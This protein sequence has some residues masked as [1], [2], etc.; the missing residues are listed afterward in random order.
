MIGVRDVVLICHTRNN[1]EA[2]LQ[3]LRKLIGR[4]F[5]RRSIN[6]V[7]DILLFSPLR[8][9]IIQLFH[10]FQGKCSAFLRCMG[11]TEHP[12]THL[13][14]TGITEGYRTVV[15]VEE[16]INGLPLL[17]TCKRT[18]L[19]ENR[20][21]IG[22]RPA[23]TLMTKAKCF[24]AKLEPLIQNL[25]ERLFLSFR[26]AGNIHKIDCNNA[27]IEAAIVLM[28]SALPET[29]LIFRQ[30]RTAAHAG[31]D[32]SP[33]ILFHLLCGNIIRH[34][35][36][37]R[38]LCG[39]F[40]KIVIGRIFM[41]VVFIQH[42]NQFRESRRNPY[43]LLILHPLHPLPEHLFN[44]HRKVIPKRAFLHLI[45][46]HKHRNEGSLSVTG[47]ERNQLILNGLNAA[48]NFFLQPTVHNLIN[49][50][51]LHRLSRLFPLLYHGFP[52]LLSGNVYKGSQMRKGKGLSAILIRSNLRHNLRSHIA[53]GKEAVR[54]FNHGLRNHRSVLE[55]IFQV[56]EIAVMFFLRIVIRV[57]K[58]DNPLLMRMH[59]IF[60]KEQTL[61]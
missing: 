24:M 21:H 4:G 42:I 28:L 2:L 33:L 31:V 37:C 40:R 22:N 7:A 13:I 20:R 16:F 10:H 43:T 59:D 15:V 44:N 29:F 39:K 17:Q 9:G 8:T 12:Y 45:Q 5:H 53:G 48:F 3:R 27:L 52:N 38:A 49:D 61:R 57:M 56:D 51:I 14:E 55:H 47:H 34:H 36:F 23:K 41:N 50:G 46:I 19:P 6:G 54:L 58:M 1:A 25:P 60:R 18:V 35:P 26:G 32:V 11:N 30:E